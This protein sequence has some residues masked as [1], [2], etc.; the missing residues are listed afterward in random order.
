MP[1]DNY[2]FAKVLRAALVRKSLANNITLWIEIKTLKAP[3]QSGAFF[4]PGVLC[5]DD[6][7]T[8]S[9]ENVNRENFLLFEAL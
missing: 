3:D 2:L 6:I 9:E 5:L 8:L 1:Y 4:I 7:I